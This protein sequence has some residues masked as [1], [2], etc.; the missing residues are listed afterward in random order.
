MAD[1][2]R[3]DEAVSGALGD[4]DAGRRCFVAKNDS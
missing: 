4:F 2:G 3:S 1:A